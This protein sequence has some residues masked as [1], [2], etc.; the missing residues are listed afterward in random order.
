MRQVIGSSAWSVGVVVPARNEEPTIE[1]C[2]DSIFASL[3]ACTQVDSSWVAV[4][5]DSCTDRT[6]AMARA[7]LSGRGELIE[8]TASSAGMARRLGVE[9]V[10]RRFAAHPADRV[11]IANTDADSEPAADWITRQLTLADQG[12]CGVAGIVQVEDSDHHKADVIRA[13]LED[14]VLHPDGTHPH[15]HGANLGIRADAYLDAGGWSDLALAEDHCLWT[16]VRARGWK[17]VSS[18]ASVVTT[19]GRLNG[20]AKGGFADTLRRKLEWLCA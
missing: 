8:C 18:I 15:V 11:W 2:I 12:Y 14:Y 7:M 9:R 20:R 19:S 16:R 17:L 6:S 10:L 4:V 3:D 13:L 1:A 5:A